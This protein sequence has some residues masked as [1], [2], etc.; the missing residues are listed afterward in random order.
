MTESRSTRPRSRHAPYSASAAH[1]RTRRSG[2][3]SIG[4]S[5]ASCA[6]YARTRHQRAVLDV[7]GLVATAAG[8]AIGGL[9]RA[10]VGAVGAASSS[11][12]RAAPRAVGKRRGAVV[13][14]AHHIERPIARAFT[15]AEAVEL[16]RRLRASNDEINPVPHRPDVQ[17]AQADAALARQSLGDE[18]RS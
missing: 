18:R 15:L 3:R 2:P 9:R 5:K 7:G 12:Q 10:V 6:S 13:I 16:M 11:V 4:S 14:G 17:S 8:Y 1:Q